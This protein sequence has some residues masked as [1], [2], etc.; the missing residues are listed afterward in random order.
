MATYILKRKTF[1]E[2]DQSQ[3]KGMGLGTKLALGAAAVGGAFLGAKHGAFG[4][5][6]Q[7]WTGKQMMNA[8][9]VK[10][11]ANTRA[12]A[13]LTN[14]KKN[15]SLVS[16]FN[17][18]TEAGDKKFLENTSKKFQNIKSDATQT[19]IQNFQKGIQDG[20]YTSAKQRKANVVQTQRTAETQKRVGDNFMNT[21]FQ[22]PGTI[23]PEQSQKVINDIFNSS[24]TPTITSNSVPNSPYKPGSLLF[25]Q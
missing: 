18:G 24:K 6:A 3:K 10:S 21:A 9:F 8:G 12:K 5:K 2:E 23:K 13:A 11:G 17:L 20:K 15:D 4:A 1:A 14:A 25:K 7:N 19:K 22:A 16:K